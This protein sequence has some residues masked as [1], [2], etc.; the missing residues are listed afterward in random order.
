MLT[1]MRA[2]IHAKHSKGN[3]Q[4]HALALT[5]TRRF[6]ASMARG[7]QH[8]TTNTPAGNIPAAAHT[9]ARADPARLPFDDAL[10]FAHTHP[11]R[12]I[13]EA[14]PASTTHAP[15]CSIH[16]LPR[17]CRCRCTPS[18]RNMHTPP[19]IAALQTSAAQASIQ[20][21]RLPPRSL[22]KRLRVQAQ[23]IG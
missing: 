21:S 4:H 16:A 14:L 11:R 2:R 1:A 10:R 18:S 12:Q 15:A 17:R 3:L 7:Y 22:P 23:C 9:F 19:R 5:G 13:E 20:P 8:S 6:H